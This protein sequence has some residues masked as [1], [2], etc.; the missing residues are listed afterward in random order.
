MNKLSGLRPAP[1][2]AIPNAGEILRASAS[3]AAIAGTWTA[4]Y[5]TMRVRNKEITAEEAIRYTANSAAVGAGAG[6][7]A[8]IASQVA[9]N[10]PLLGLAA[11]A[12]GV[13]YIA[14]TSHQAGPVP[15]KADAP[16]PSGPEA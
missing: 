11:L 12:A 1:N 3:G 7:V 5:E 15:A 10:I 13:V 2:A 14:S 6:A 16:Q 8:H 4:I 9:R